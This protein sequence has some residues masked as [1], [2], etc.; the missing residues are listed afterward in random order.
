MAI[1]SVLR[2]FKSLV[3]MMRIFAMVIMEN[4]NVIAFFRI[5]EGMVVKKSL[6]IGN[7][8]RIIS[9]IAMV[10]SI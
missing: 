6:I 1:I 7:K 9:I 5:V 10:R 2:R 8:S 3:M 4:I